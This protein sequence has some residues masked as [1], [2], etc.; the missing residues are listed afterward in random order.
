MD[1]KQDRDT[2]KDS[3]RPAVELIDDILEIYVC[4]ET[5]TSRIFFL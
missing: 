1:P 3:Q 5:Q 4:T 2:S